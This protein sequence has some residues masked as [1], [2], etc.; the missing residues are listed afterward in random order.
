VF[1]IMLLVYVWTK[2][3]V[4]TRALTSA[5]GRVDTRGSFNS[6]YLLARAIKLDPLRYH[7]RNIVRLLLE[8]EIL[9]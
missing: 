2:K 1:I 4:G 6:S 3:T 7:V 8:P 9:T 5:V